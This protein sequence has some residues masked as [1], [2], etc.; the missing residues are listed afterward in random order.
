MWVL[1]GLVP[2]EEDSFGR[3]RQL[4]RARR[5]APEAAAAEATGREPPET[6]RPRQAG[7]EPPRR[8]ASAERR[9]DQRSNL[10]DAP[11]R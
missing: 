10:G 1:Y 9:A 8:R 7:A 5:G 3:L 2:L 6:A 11:P 4:R